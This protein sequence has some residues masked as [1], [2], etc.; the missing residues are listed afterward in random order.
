MIIY[1][2]VL[3]ALN[4]L[5]TYILI[6]ASRV[7]CK[8]PTNKWAVLVASVVGG[9]T[10]LV[11][12]YENVSV[13]FSCFYKIITGV[14]IVGIAFL[15]KSKKTFLKALIAFLGV[16]LLFGG[17]MYA[18]EI[19]LHPQKIM[20]YNGIVYFDMS[21]TYLVSAVLVIYGAFVV[22]DYYLTKH[23]SKGGKCQLEVVNNN[24][25]VTMTALI[26]T[27]NTL[28]DGLTGRP[29]IVAELLSLTPLFSREEVMFFKSGAFQDIPE[30]L[31][32]SFRLV[33]CRTV[34]GESL[35]KAFVP[36]MVK[37][38]NGKNC[39]V[40]EFCTVALVNKELSQGEYRA[41]VNKNIFAYV[42]EERENE[43]INA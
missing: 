21:I 34:S 3:I 33:P 15:P 7:L 16:S 1:A 26:D 10:S 17:V 4:I 39:C 41:L 28:T 31:N 5:L 19:T 2:D 13:L 14:I 36:E 25:S 12:F 38:K 43:K 18:L 8:L 9:F 24:K 37:I 30:S 42:K 32:K 11:I 6:V 23:I 29:V 35:L 22:A 40:L 27:G 20:L